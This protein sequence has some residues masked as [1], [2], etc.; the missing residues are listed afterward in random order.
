MT[1]PDYDD[2]GQ[3]F[4]GERTTPRQP[5]LGDRRFDVPKLSESIAPDRIPELVPTD[6]RMRG[7]RQYDQK[8]AIDPQRYGGV[9]TDGA[10]DTWH[11]GRLVLVWEHPVTGELRRC[12]AAP[13]DPWTDPWAADNERVLAETRRRMSTG[14]W[15]YSDAFWTENIKPVP[16]RKRTLSA[17]YPMYTRW[18]RFRSWWWH[19]THRRPE[20]VPAA[21][22]TDDEEWI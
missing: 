17:Q 1:T 14:G 4:Y 3:P 22:C 19:A 11:G 21:D 9:D 7:W 5:R 13:L 16:K 15:T 10:D 8:R 12:A 18:G 2:L 20:P 6:P